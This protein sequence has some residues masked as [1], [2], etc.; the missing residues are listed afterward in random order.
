MAVEHAKLHA[1]DTSEEFLYSIRV[2]IFAHVL[3]MSLD[4]LV[5]PYFW[6]I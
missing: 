4:V 3:M 1:N 6:L 2:D 5:R